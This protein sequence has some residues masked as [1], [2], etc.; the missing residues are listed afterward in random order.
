MLAGFGA[1]AQAQQ[2]GSLQWRFSVDGSVTLS[3]PA[4]SPDGQ[5]V[6]V[7]VETR[8]GGRVV[9]I[10]ARDGGPRTSWG[11]QGRVLADPVESSPAVSADG[12]T[13]YVG[14]ANGTLYALRA[15]NGSTLWELSLGTFITSSPAIGTDGTIYVGTGDGRVR[16]V[17]PQGAPLWVFPTGS[18]IFSSP[19]IGSDG[20][21]YIGSYDRHLYALTPGGEEK[22]RFLTGGA[23][24]SSPAIGVDGTIYIGS[25]DQRMYAIAPDGSRRWDYL[26]NGPLDASPVLGPDGTVYF[27]SDRSFYALKRQPDADQVRWK[28]DIATG[29]ISS[30]AVRAD[31]TVIF[32]A[33]DGVIRGLNAADGSE[34]WRYDTRTGQGN[35]IESSPMI[36]PDGSI[37]VGSFDG[38]LYKLNGNGSPLSTYSSWPAFRHDIR[39]TGRLL[40]S[41][42]GN[43]LVNI[44]TRAQAG[45]GRNLIAG[46]VVQ[47]PAGRAYLVRAVG[48]GLAANNVVGFMPNPRLEMYSL[49]SHVPFRV[50][51]NWLENDET[52]GLSL[53]ETAGAV[54]AFPLQS[55][56]A[57]A[58]ILPALISGAF[59]AHVEAAAGPAGVALVEVYD[60]LAGDPNAR[61]LNLSTRGFVGTN[62]NIL[63]AGFVVSGT[64]SMRL[65]L[66]GFGPAL[67]QFGVPGVLMQPTLTLFSG[68]TAIASNTGWTSD[69]LKHDIISAGAAVSAFPLSETSADSVLLFDAKP[70]PYTLQ[71]SGVGDRTGEAMVEIYVLP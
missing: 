53:V 70:G 3:S 46:F 27:A 39:R 30:A 45:A 31:G 13:I 40:P 28:R 52:N 23:I 32:G 26:T 49:S 60:G 71:I 37:Y 9:A 24:F 61:I 42:T 20:T 67:S 15:T 51:D 36:G 33:D 12:S 21:I 47:A 10:S 66:R 6:Y 48:P 41:N 7:G 34:K 5:T 29:S 68:S 64:G 44:S 17:T 58:A 18:F 57:D 2:D 16:A 43:R 38:A 69:G 56:S 63:I 25:G 8:S 11:A 55:G 62:E 35:L 59:T 65:L 19:A 1:V 14:T 50:N 54:Q 22:W 4:L